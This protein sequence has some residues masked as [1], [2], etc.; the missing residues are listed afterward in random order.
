MQKVPPFFNGH[1]PGIT[2]HKTSRMEWLRR[3]PSEM[4]PTENRHQGEQIPALTPRP[5]IFSTK[6]LLTDCRANWGQAWNQSMA[7]QFTRAGNFL[8]RVLR[9]K[10]TGEKQSTTCEGTAGCRVT[11][12]TAALTKT[13]LNVTLETASQL[14]NNT[15]T[16]LVC[17]CTA[18]QVADFLY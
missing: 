11:V 1:V 16:G 12:L 17:N 9:V 5:S 7:L 10:P 18:E 15:E 14:Q 4:K 13:T 6:V 8:A 3:S 2:E